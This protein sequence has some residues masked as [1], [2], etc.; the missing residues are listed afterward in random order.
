M[1]IPFYSQVMHYVLYQLQIQL[2]NIID[3]PLKPSTPQSVRILKQDQISE[4]HLKRF[5]KL[6]WHQTISWQE[7]PYRKAVGSAQLS[8]LALY[9]DARS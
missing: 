5:C 9:A 6:N 2:A 8:L 1:I 4:L 3:L 7:R